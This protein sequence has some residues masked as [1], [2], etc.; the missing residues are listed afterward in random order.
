MC[1]MC[2]LLSSRM[3]TLTLC[4]RRLTGSYFFWYKNLPER[5]FTDSFPSPIPAQEWRVQP[6]IFTAAIPV[7][8][9][10]ARFC[11]DLPP[12]LSMI[13]R[14]R[15]DLP[16]PWLQM[17]HSRNIKEE[18]EL[19]AEPVKNTL[20][21][22]LTWS[23][24][25]CWSRDNTISVLGGGPVED[26]SGSG[27]AH[28]G[29]KSDSFCGSGAGSLWGALAKDTLKSGIKPQ[30]LNT[31]LSTIALLLVETEMIWRRI[32]ETSIPIKSA[33]FFIPWDGHWRLTL[34]LHFQSSQ[35]PI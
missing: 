3:S 25:R 24:I 10:I 26:G 28:G 31:H 13:A 14:S 18:T 22:C 1:Q 12:K 5:S 7:D 21:P 19:P 2:N 15:T 30:R 8:A 32:Q 29:S 27:C 17:F 23:S 33:S 16:V 4:H 34:A 6:P 11:E 9:V 20:R 35:I